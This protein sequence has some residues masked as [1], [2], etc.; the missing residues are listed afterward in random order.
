MISPDNSTLPSLS[1]SILPA[2]LVP[3]LFNSAHTHPPTSYKAETMQPIGPTHS[4]RLGRGTL[5]V[6]IGQVCYERDMGGYAAA[7]PMDHSQGW[8]VW[9]TCA[10]W[11]ATICLPLGCAVI[12]FAMAVQTVVLVRWLFL[13]GGG[14]N[15]DG[16]ESGHTGPLLVPL[17]GEWMVVGWVHLYGMH[18]PP[19]YA[20]PRMDHP[21][22][23]H[24]DPPVLPHPDRNL[25]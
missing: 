13:E 2:H 17:V 10:A 14:G 24:A 12:A 3:S 20:D 11:S 23:P 18:S 1:P 6:G 25:P 8:E 16:G 5:T 22:V 15:T 19:S 21:T 4:R 9:S 7:G